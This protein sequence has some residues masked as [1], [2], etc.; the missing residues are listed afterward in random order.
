[1]SATVDENI[2]AFLVKK[3]GWERVAVKLIQAMGPG[4]FLATFYTKEEILSVLSK[5]DIE[6]ALQEVPDEEKVKY[7]LAKWGYEK[8]YNK[9]QEMNR[10]QTETR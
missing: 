1:M 10:N 4:K 8:L 5:E 7:L 2:I 9:I 6:A 3:F